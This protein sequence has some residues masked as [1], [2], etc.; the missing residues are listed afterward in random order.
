MPTR[1][2]ANI[3]RPSSGHSSAERRFA[4]R[5]G[6]GISDPRLT[7]VRGDIADIGLAGAIFVPHYVEPEP[8]SVASATMLRARPGECEPA[9][10]QL[11][12]GETFMLLDVEGGWAW[13]WCAHDHYV[14]FLPADALIAPVAASHVVHVRSALAFA[15]P[16]IKSTVLTTHPMGTRLAGSCEAGGWLA[17]A[18]GGYVHARHATAL[19]T[20][21]ADPVALAE[22]LVGAPYVWGGRAGDGLDCSGL[23]QLVHGLVGIALPRDSDQIAEAG[24][25]VAS[26]AELRRGDAVCFP[27]HIGLMVDSD[28]MVHANAHWMAVTIEPLDAVLARFDDPAAAIVGMRRFA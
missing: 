15:E 28:R 17:L 23:V 19:I 26:R 25:A 22:A 1:R 21:A 14:G 3:G 5:G 18:A 7:A 24:E 2:F 13:G 9:T 16:D 12:G 4:L 27:G 11:L 20:L 8:R 10:T 6:R